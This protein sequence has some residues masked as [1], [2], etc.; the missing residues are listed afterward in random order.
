MQSV[1]SPFSTLF[2]SWSDQVHQELKRKVKL[3]KEE[4]HYW[5]MFLE[6]HANRFWRRKGI[7]RQECS[8]FLPCCFAEENSSLCLWCQS[9]ALIKNSCCCTYFKEEGERVGLKWERVNSLISTRPR[10]WYG[11]A[12]DVAQAGAASLKVW[13]PHQNAK[14]PLEQAGGQKRLSGRGS[15]CVKVGLVACIIG[16]SGGSASIL[17]FQPLLSML[18]WNPLR[19]TPVHKST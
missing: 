11:S 7:I 8:V 1:A 2:N 9:T 17:C 4:G 19:F 13:W 3:G 15:E 5:L 16:G 6:G 14:T 12:Y 10:V 18:F